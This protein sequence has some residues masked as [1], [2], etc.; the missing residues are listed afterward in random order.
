MEEELFYQPF[1]ESAGGAKFFT[2]AKLSPSRH[3]FSENRII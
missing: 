2:K 3:N 1:Q